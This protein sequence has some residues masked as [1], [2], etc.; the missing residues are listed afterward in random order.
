MTNLI[1]ASAGAIFS[2]YARRGG[3][4]GTIKELKSGLHLGQRQVTKAKERVRRSV[5]PSVFASLLLVWLYGREE[6]STKAWSLFKLKERCIGE[7]AQ[8]AIRRTELKWQR[9]LQQVKDV[10]SCLHDD[11]SLLSI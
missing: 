4:E 3:V 7:V 5:A 9:K 6:A 8:E 11:P 1:E 2:I 10:A